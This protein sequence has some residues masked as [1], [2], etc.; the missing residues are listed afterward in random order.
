M[1]AESS[2]IW[3]GTNDNGLNVYNTVTDHF[4]YYKHKEND[5]ESL[6]GNNIKALLRLSSGNMAIGSHDGGLCI[7]QKNNRFKRVNISSDQ[8]A[9]SN[10]YS[11]FQDENNILWVGTLNGLFLYDF[12]SESGESVSTLIKTK[13]LD[14]KQIMTLYSDSKK[15]LWIGTDNG[16]YIYPS[17]LRK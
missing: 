1:L 7:L 5:P 9:N 14:D 10:V 4:S 8:T 3:I 6:S 12:K 17:S 11:L 16:L 2:L 13:V 15:R